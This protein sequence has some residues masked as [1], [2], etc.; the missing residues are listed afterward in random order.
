MAQLKYQEELQLCVLD[1]LTVSPGVRFGT[2]WLWERLT[3]WGPYLPGRRDWS[4][5]MLSPWI[6]ASPPPAF[7][8]CCTPGAYTRILLCW[9]E[10]QERCHIAGSFF[11]LHLPAIKNSLRIRGHR[12]EFL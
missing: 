3:W 4:Q 7:D 1:L 10:A 5:R 2:C 12:G 8:F 9:A 11:Y 6:S